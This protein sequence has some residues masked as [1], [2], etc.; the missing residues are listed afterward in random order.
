MKYTEQFFIFLFAIFFSGYSLEAQ[1]STRVFENVNDTLISD[2]DA[3]ITEYHF[4]LPAGTIDVP[5]V[6]TGS[7]EQLIK[8]DNAN[9]VNKN[10]KSVAFDLAKFLIP[11]F[12][13]FP[14]Y[15]S[16]PL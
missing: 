9:T 2:F 4:L 5:V 10:I 8:K 15:A 3:G 11:F 7:C 13:N 1:E 12:I 6:P 14:P 16:N